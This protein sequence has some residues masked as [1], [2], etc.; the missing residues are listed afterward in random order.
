VVGGERRVLAVQRAHSR[1]HQLSVDPRRGK[2]V[3]A[4]PQDSA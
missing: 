4:C 3:R 1:A 2:A